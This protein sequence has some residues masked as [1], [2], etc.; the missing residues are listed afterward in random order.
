MTRNEITQAINKQFLCRIAFNGKD[1]PQIAPF[2]Y[3][4]M[5]NYIYFHFTS[6][7]D[8]MDFLNEGKQVCV[9]IENYAPDFSEYSFV[10]LNG[11][12][13]VVQ[14][15]MIKGKVIEKMA[16][17]GKAKLSERFLFAHGFDSKA[18]WSIL[19]E[20]Q[21]LLIVKLFRVDNVKGLKSP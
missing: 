11:A 14:D 18:G 12:L 17:A 6:Y 5:D 9:E 10:T 21:D 7:G 8:K 13:E 4:F 16:E 1:G 15:P 2:Q 3:I 19:N 20:N